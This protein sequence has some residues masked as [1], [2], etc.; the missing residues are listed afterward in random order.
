MTSRVFGWPLV[1]GSFGLIFGLII[2]EAIV[3]ILEVGVLA[4][5][6]GLAIGGLIGFIVG[7]W[8][9]YKT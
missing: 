3:S 2:G 7:L 6:R 9:E 4:G 1:L 5:P 8:L